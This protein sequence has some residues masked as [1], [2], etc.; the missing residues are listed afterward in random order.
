MAVVGAVLV[1]V[2]SY[3]GTILGRVLGCRTLRWLGAR[4]YGIYLWHWPIMQLTRPYVDVPLHGAP[5]I[6]AQAALTIGA[7]ALSYRYLEMPIRTGVAQKQIRG[8]FDRRRPRERLAWV[9][10]GAC[11]IVTAAGLGF[12]LPAPTAAAFSSTAT[13]SA[14]RTL[15]PGRS[16]TTLARLGGSAG[17]A[18]DRRR[19]C[20]ERRNA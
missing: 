15:A 13:P 6:V 17:L 5:L 14:L 4:S 7:A 1:S 20:P 3:P 12:G 10:G 8:W 11:A 2:V 19:R 9:S 16:S 18:S